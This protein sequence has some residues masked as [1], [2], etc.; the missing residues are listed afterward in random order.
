MARTP[1]T[2]AEARQ[3]LEQ[4]IPTIRGRYVEGVGRADWE[5]GASS[6]ASEENYSAGVAEAVATKSRQLGVRRAGNA[7]W[8]S[9]AEGKGAAAI[10]AGVRR[11]LDAY[12][13]NFG[14][15]YDAMVAAAA[16][17]PARTRDIA[18]NVANRVTPVAMA[19]HEAARRQR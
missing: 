10:E 4:S 11:G 6:D 12:A 15:V 9:G 13:S 17:L 1:K 14:P 19:A 8:R 2:L 3:N 5:S 16:R 18:T 7:K